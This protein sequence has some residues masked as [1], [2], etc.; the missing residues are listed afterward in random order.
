MSKLEDDLEEALHG[1]G[2]NH[3]RLCDCAPTLSDLIRAFRCAG[4]APACERGEDFLVA[5]VS[6]DAKVVGVEHATSADWHAVKA[7]HVALRDYLSARIANA[8]KC[9]A[10]LREPSDG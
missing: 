2:F 10:A 3:F 1:V 8:G 4:W 5:R 7:A 6:P 9:P